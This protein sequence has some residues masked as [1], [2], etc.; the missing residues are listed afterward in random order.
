MNLY[1][2]LGV[3]KNASKAEIK[4][5]YRKKALD[6]H[7]D[8]HA[9]N[10]TEFIAVRNAYNTLINDATRAYYDQT[11]RTD[12]DDLTPAEMMAMSLFDELI[13]SNL[14]GDVNFVQM[15][16]TVQYEKIT[17]ARNSLKQVNIVKSKLT[18]M[19]GRVTSKQISLFE[20]L[21]QKRI[22]HC[23]LEILRFE[24]SIKEL[25]SC[26]EVLK[27]HDDQYTPPRPTNPYAAFI[28]QNGL[29]GFNDQA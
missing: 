17:S 29:R 22:E 15:A 11:G 12:P 1:E 25:E 14:D 21:L 20:R 6:H 5:A 10:E 18:K 13:Y 28:N 23:D 3:A 7:P 19:I 16:I 27:T 26:I 9:G 2:L 8:R 4:A 24:N